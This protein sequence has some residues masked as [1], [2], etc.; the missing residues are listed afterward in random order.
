MGNK[1]NRL[2]KFQYGN[3]VTTNDEKLKASF[4]GREFLTVVHGKFNHKIK[5]FVY[6]FG[7]IRTKITEGVLKAY[8]E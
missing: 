3:K 4:D 1:I 6:S 7:E 8:E 2:P 5:N